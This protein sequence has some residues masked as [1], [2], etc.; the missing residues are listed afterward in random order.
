L[1]RNLAQK[2]QQQQ[3]AANEA[4]AKQ[5]E[6]DRIRQEA[7]EGYKKTLAEQN[8][9]KPKPNPLAQVPGATR[10]RVPT[11]LG[12]DGIDLSKLPPNER[13]KAARMR[14]RQRGRAME[15]K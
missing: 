3:T 10:S 9:T 15:R 13:M 2:Q 12:D 7:I 11:E 8:Q 1:K 5:A 14:A 6:L 4:A